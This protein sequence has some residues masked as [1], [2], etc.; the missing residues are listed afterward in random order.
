[1]RRV[2]RVAVVPLAAAIVLLA[3]AAGAGAADAGEEAPLAPPG[4]PQSAP[5]EQAAEAVAPAPPPPPAAAPPRPAPAPPP[6]AEADARRTA[7][8]KWPLEVVR[9]PLTLPAGMASFEVQLTG[10]R[11]KSH[12]NVDPATGFVYTFNSSVAGGLNLTVG[13][14]D[15]IQ[16]AVFVPE[17]VCFA[18]DT[19]SGCD[20]INSHTGTGGSLRVLVLR[21]GGVQIAPW[22][23]VSVARTSPTVMRWSAGS[24]FKYTASDVVALFSSP[25]VA[26][27]FN[28]P[29][30]S[31]ANPWLAYVPV[32]LEVQAAQRAVVYGVVEPWGSIGDVARGVLLEVY[33]GASYTF[34]SFGEVGLEGGT[35]NVL[36]QPVWNRNVP[37]YFAQ[38][39]LVLW[40][41]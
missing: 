30:Q 19:P 6:A 41:A 10:R 24:A 18:A 15:N 17:L 29:P 35:Y 4:D 5:A 9:R 32:E 25:A 33:G 8:E 38:L 11:P 1:M 39:W 7:D 36:S 27:N 21:A 13:L 12:V 40:K 22:A 3:R 20:G 37:E 14:D 31:P 23:G 34:G 28:P 16:L 26:R 2:Q